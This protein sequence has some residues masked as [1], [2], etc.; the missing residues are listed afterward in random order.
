MVIMKNVLVTGG[1]G[2]IGSHAC[3]ALRAHGYVPITFDDLGRGHADLVKWGPLVRGN[4]LDAEA[5]DHAFAEWKPFAV[6]HFAA[7][8]YVGESVSDPLAYYR[9]NVVGSLNLMD[10]MRKHRVRRLVFSST[11]ATY[12]RPLTSLIA[13][14]HTQNPI[15]P[16]GSSKLMVET[17]LRDFAGANNLRVVALR[18]FN[19]AGA[20]PDGETGEDHSPETHLIPCAL[21]ATGTNATPLTVFGTDYETPDGTCVRDFV[22]VSDLANAHVLALNALDATTAE[23]SFRAYN[24][25][26]GKGYSVSQVLDAVERV[27]GQA[28]QRIKGARRA[29]DPA[30]LVGNAELAIRELGWQPKFANLDIIVKTAWHW[31]M[32]RHGGFA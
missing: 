24:L 13:E 31:H 21:A 4:L 19:A 18:Y 6:L 7:F 9:N 14:G 16:Y 28:P 8:A 12:G 22:H 1:A 2:Y 25:G 3:K 23:S 29:G 5:L 27:T 20:D 11:C 32:Q 26:N 17:I 10:A 30:V 15:N